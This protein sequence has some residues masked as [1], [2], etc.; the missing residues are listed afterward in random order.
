MRRISMTSLVLLWVA[1]QAQDDARLWIEELRSDR[2][3]R[4]ETAMHK[5]K[6]LGASALVKRLTD[7]SPFVRRAAA[8]ALVELKVVEIAPELLTLLTSPD[9]RGLAARVLGAIRWKPAAPELR[10]LLK[11]SAAAAGCPGGGAPRNRVRAGVRS[12]PRPGSNAGGRV[13]APVE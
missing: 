11:D 4:R 7:T 8:D 10:K 3:D 13:L 12:D 5:L 9:A 6:D 1:S 2:I